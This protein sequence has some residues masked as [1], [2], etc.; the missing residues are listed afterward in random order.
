M[1]QQMHI[2]WYPGHMKKTKE[3]L[4]SSMSLVDVVVEVV[5][6]RIPKAS[7]NP[8]IDEI[9]G[10]K[11]RIIILNKEDLADPRVT[12]K[13]IK[14]YSDLGYIAIA[15]NATSGHGIDKLHG[16]INKAFIPTK[17]KL[18]KKNMNVRAPRILIAGIPNSGKSSLINKLSGKKSTQTGDRPGV[19][20]GKQWVRLRGNLEMLDTPGILWPKFED[21]RVSMLLAFTGAIKDDILNVEEIG[22][23]LLKLMQENYFESLQNRYNLDLSAESETIEIMDSIAIKRGFFQKG[24]EIDYLRTAKAIL[25]EF[26]GGQLGRISLETPEDL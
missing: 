23:Q 1:E 7:K 10:N 3:L 13:W 25:N 18:E 15:M 11:A 17:E 24:K 20:K 26:R 21:E 19:T 5:D 14:Y 2:N 12:E 16:A 8:D 9:A 4:K 6:S 22:F